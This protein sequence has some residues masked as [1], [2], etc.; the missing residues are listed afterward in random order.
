MLEEHAIFFS[1]I[2]LFLCKFCAN[3]MSSP[4]LKTDFL[5]R[6]KASVFRSHFIENASAR[7][8]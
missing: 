4:N 8:K 5:R 3:S 2:M 7:G 1:Q 6:N